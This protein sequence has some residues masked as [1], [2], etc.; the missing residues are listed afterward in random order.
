M[1]P[2]VINVQVSLGVTPQ[3][4]SL[5]RSFLPAG[6]ATAAAPVENKPAAPQPEAK[7]ATKKN[8]KQ[9]P[10]PEAKQEPAAAPAETEAP[11]QDP[12]PAKEEQPADKQYSEED[13]R[14]A[15]DKTRKRIEGEDYKDNT[16]SEGYKAYHRELTAC[17]KQLAKDCGAEK[18]SA[19]PDSESR[20][21]FVMACDYIAATEDGKVGVED[22]TF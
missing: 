2:I 8:T 19:L 1:D 15:M 3:L 17:F 6:E 5:V 16:G 7:P 12:A 20:K 4:E 13:V 22:L 21:R 11:A 10:A 14:A 9:Q 18:P